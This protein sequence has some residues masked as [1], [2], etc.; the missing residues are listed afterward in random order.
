MQNN[1]EEELKQYYA[2]GTNFLISLN[3]Y[4]QKPATSGKI[5]IFILEDDGIVLL[6]LSITK[7]ELLFHSKNKTHSIKLRMNPLKSFNIRLKQESGTLLIFSNCN[8]VFNG[9]QEVTEV[10]DERLGLFSE[11]SSIFLHEHVS[12]PLSCQEND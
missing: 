8:L 3:F 10:G 2:D 6:A 9:S 5:P 1:A 11:K 7:D 12:Q 4:L